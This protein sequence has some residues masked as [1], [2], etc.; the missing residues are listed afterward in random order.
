MQVENSGIVEM[1]EEAKSLL[2]SKIYFEV[3]DVEI[4]WNFDMVSMEH[5]C[6]VS[7]GKNFRTYSFSRKLLTDI[8][9]NPDATEGMVR[10]II[11]EI[12]RRLL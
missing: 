10:G 11:S 8:S 6:R 1:E 7:K 5:K 4:E 2:E 9:T 3:P 12:K